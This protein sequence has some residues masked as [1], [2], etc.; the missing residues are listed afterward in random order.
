MLQNT[1]IKEASSP[2]PQADVELDALGKLCPWPLVLAKRALQSM[3]S[4]KI[5]RVLSDDPL[6]E[7]DIRALCERDGHLLLRVG[8]KDGH[9]GRI[10][11]AMWIQKRMATDKLSSPR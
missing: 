5:L 4:G 10:E 9:K 11:I 3:Q 1:D 2:D 7:L 6:A 8:S